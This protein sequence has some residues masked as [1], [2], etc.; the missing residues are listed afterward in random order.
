MVARLHA[1][2]AFS[3]DLA[4]AKRE[5]ARVKAKPADCG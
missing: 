2:P 4:K 1:D 3:A 5:L